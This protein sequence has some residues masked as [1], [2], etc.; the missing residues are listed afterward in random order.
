MM[1]GMKAYNYDGGEK[2][3]LHQRNENPEY[4]E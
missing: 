1:H 2:R 3:V 4:Q